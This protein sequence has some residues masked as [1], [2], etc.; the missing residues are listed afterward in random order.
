MKKVS[1]TNKVFTEN[2]LLDEIVYN[3]RQLATGVVVKDPDLADKYETLES[4]QNGDILIAIKSGTIHFENFIYDK[5]LLSL[6]YVSSQKIQYY[7]EDNSRIPK[8]DREALLKIAT[9]AFL[10]NYEE[11][12]SY[13][14]SLHGLPTTKYDDQTGIPIWHGIWINPTKIDD[15]NPTAISDISSFEKEGYVLIH[16]LD[17]AY[18]NILFE[19]GT[20]ESIVDDSNWLMINELTKDDVMYLMH[21]GEREIDYYDAR[22]AD[23]FSLLYCPKCDAEEVRTRFKDLYESN[24]MYFLYTSYSEAYK[25][26]SD[27]YNN[28]VMILLVIQTI[29]DM[30]IELPEYIIRRDIFDTRTCKYIFESNG[31]K[32]FKDIPLKY[33][34]ALVKNLNKLIK[35]K[36]TDKCIVDIVSLFGTENLQVF[37]YY[38]MKDRRVGNIKDLDY[39]SNTKTIRD[40]MGNTHIEEDNDKNYDIRFIKVPMLDKYDEHIRR[41]SNIRNYESMTDGDSTWQGDKMY[42]TVLKDIKDLDFTVL[43]S[44]YYSIEAV[45]DL[46]KKNFTVVYFMNMLMYNN[47]DKAKLQV[48]LPSIST[49]KKFELVDTIIALYSLS[50]IYYGVEDTILDSRAKA[51]QILGFNLEADL[52]KISSWLNETHMGLTLKDL[53]VDFSVPE[54]GKIM[55]FKEL[56]D[57]FLKNKDCYDHI[58]NV[59][60]DPPSKEI[61]DIY[62]HLYKALMTT[63]RN[64]ECFIIKDRDIIDAYKS[65]GFKSKF[66]TIPKKEQYHKEEDYHRDYKWL[67]ES[68]DDTTLCFDMNENFDDN[69]KYDL[70]IKEGDTLKQVGESQMAYTYREYLRYKDIKLYSYIANIVAIPDMESRREACV[71]A[72]QSITSYLKDYIDRDVVSL[73]TVF[74]GLPSISFDFIKKYV[75]EVIDFFKSFKIFTH[76][77]SIIYT[78]TDKFDNYVQLVDHILL[79]YLFDKSEL[80]KIEDALGGTVKNI[81][82]KLINAG[83]GITNHLTHKERASMIDKVWFEISTWIKKN[84]TDFYNSDRYEQAAAR[85]KESVNMTYTMTMA[86]EAIAIDTIVGLLVDLDLNESV[87]I[88]EGISTSY[89][90]AMSDRYDLWLTDLASLVIRKS[91]ADRMKYQD[92]YLR[93]D[94]Y[95]WYLKYFI[96]D[97]IERKNIALNAKSKIDYHDD[98][99][100]IVTQQFPPHQFDE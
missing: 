21:I 2:P 7:A 37:R 97:G 40:T 25:Y 67:I 73:D 91:F 18:K 24:R 79:K 38:I 77:S 95:Q 52:A 56:E 32:Y 54:N 55:S 76:G 57:I 85:I 98:C 53:K 92:D 87:S 30:V 34:V 70:Y 10:N 82:G 33:Q 15:M 62:K 90:F 99:Y 61:Y 14:R 84:F 48:N 60:R 64:M 16:E 66:I 81:N 86:D 44:K 35:F 51:A 3:A 26:R 94:F 11:L 43:R 46:A 31:V 4:L 93:S 89:R 83:N 22:I 100:T 28:F 58:R 71:N 65:K 42:E 75:E 9:N 1:L 20:C 13:Y 8:E 68:I 78:A 12:N 47:I 72:I 59:M 19:N 69:H 5:D 29:I 23:K 36:S 27:Y 39:Y 49:S 6:Y 88:K 80:I 45:I 50:Y 17:L 41:N 74:S 63:N 96:F